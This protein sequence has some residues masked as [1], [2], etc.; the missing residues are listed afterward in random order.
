MNMRA[1]L[2]DYDSVAVAEALFIIFTVQRF[3][4]GLGGGIGL[5]KSICTNGNA[6][7]SVCSETKPPFVKISHPIRS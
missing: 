7:Q 6:F 1:Y 4:E 5:G 3:F 2:S